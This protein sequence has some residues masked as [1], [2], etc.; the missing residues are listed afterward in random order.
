MYREIESAPFVKLKVY[1]PPKVGISSN[2]G[3]KGVYV[4]RL[5]LLALIL[6]CLEWYCRRV[7][8]G[9]IH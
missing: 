4:G 5:P 3:F 6:R 2:F 9:L 7:T 1:V 8:I